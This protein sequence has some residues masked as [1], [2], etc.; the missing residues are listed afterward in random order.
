M[1]LEAV[2]FAATGEAV[3]FAATGEAVAFAATGEASAL[4]EVTMVKK[5]LP[6]QLAPLIPRWRARL[7]HRKFFVSSLVLF[8]RLKLTG[9]SLKVPQ[10]HYL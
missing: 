7:L 2:A 6:V 3:A 4:V 10:W 1:P 9:Q 8:S 5:G